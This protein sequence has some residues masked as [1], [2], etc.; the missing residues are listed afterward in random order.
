MQV[1]EKFAGNIA[2][3]FVCRGGITKF[4]HKPTILNG[5]GCGLVRRFLEGKIVDA[6]AVTITDRYHVHQ[7]GPARQIGDLRSHLFGVLAAL[8][9]QLIN[10]IIALPQVPQKAIFRQSMQIDRTALLN[11]GVLAGD[12][13]EGFNIG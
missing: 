9:E 3:R 8:I 11:K 1:T 5:D 7:C 12:D 4:Q 10:V 6:D 13:D 2:D